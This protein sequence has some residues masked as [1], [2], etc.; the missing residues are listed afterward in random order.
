MPVAHSRVTRGRCRHI[1]V[2]VCAYTQAL[3]VCVR[4]WMCVWG[5][6]RPPAP[7]GVVRLSSSLAM[8]CSTIVVPGCSFASFSIYSPCTCGMCIHAHT[9]M[10]ARSCV[11]GHSRTCDKMSVIGERIVLRHVPA[12]IVYLLVLAC[13]RA[14]VRWIGGIQ[15]RVMRRAGAS[16][17]AM[18]HRAMGLHDDA[19]PYA[20]GDG[21]WLLKLQRSLIRTFLPH[22]SH[23]Q[24]PWPHVP[25]PCT[26]V[27]TALRLAALRCT[28]QH[29]AAQRS[30]GQLRTAQ[31]GTALRCAWG[32]QRDWISRSKSRQFDIN[33][34]QC[35]LIRDSVKTMTRDNCDRAVKQD[36]FTKKILEDV[37]KVPK[38]V[39]VEPVTRIKP[40]QRR[41]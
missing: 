16:E 8:R 22:P 30:S 11:R 4:A 28:A 35:L 26:I 21:G 41:F 19:A 38:S 24:S 1:C 14:C 27:C 37:E 15:E 34:S 12:S 32:L 25:P 39:H 10:H 18:P 33:M 23:F 9:S 36:F 31:H 13:V 40:Q 7:A 29:S 2:C 6:V 3:R 20:H 5:L 17:T